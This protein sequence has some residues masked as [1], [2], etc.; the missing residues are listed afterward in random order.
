M[1]IEQSYRDECDTIRLLIDELEAAGAKHFIENMD[2]INEVRGGDLNEYLK[3]EAIPHIF[4]FLTSSLLV[5]CISLLEYRL[6]KLVVF[7]IRSAGIIV[8]AE[9]ETARNQNVLDW[10][11]KILKDYEGFT[12][13]FGDELGERMNAWIKLR[14]DLIHNGGYR[15]EWIK[16]RQIDILHGVKVGDIDSLYDVQFVACRNAINDVEAF[17]LKV[18]KTLSASSET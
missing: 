1:T 4:S 13:D 15:S 12:F 14:N 10:M 3:P 18:H 9:S 7:C 16:Q 6:R 8:P 5:H 11:K 2:A 17:F